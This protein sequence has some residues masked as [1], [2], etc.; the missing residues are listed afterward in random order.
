ML[1][2]RDKKLQIGYGNVIIKRRKTC[3]LLNLQCNT[4]SV[5]FHLSCNYKPWKQ[6]LRFMADAIL[7]IAGVFPLHF[8]IQV[9]TIVSL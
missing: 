5:V 3:I 7:Y 8:S 9:L 1:I 6:V 2:E 4:Y